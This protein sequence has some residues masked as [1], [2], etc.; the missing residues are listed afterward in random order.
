MIA[1]NQL[2]RIDLPKVLLIPAATFVLIMIISGAPQANAAG[3]TSTQT[4]CVDEHPCHTVTCSEDQPCKTSQTPNSDFDFDV[5]ESSFQPMESEP[6]A[7]PLEDVAP[8]EMVP[9]LNS[10]N[11]EDREDYS[12]DRQDMMEDAEYE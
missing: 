1:K 12:E 6:F 11:L 10:N 4:S 8:I 5:D 9:F 2:K 3:G 7:Q